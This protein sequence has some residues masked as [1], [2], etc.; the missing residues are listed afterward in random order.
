MKRKFLILLAI[1]A[2]Q[3]GS[4]AQVSG[5]SQ[6]PPASKVPPPP[7]GSIPSDWPVELEPY[8]PTGLSDARLRLD[9][10]VAPGTSQ[11]DSVL[12]ACYG[13]QLRRYAE[14]QISRKNYRQAAAAL[15]K[16]IQIPDRPESLARLMRAETN[17]TL[18]SSA[19]PKEK[20]KL[21][22]KALTD[23]NALLS[24]K[25]IQTK[26]AQSQLD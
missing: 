3:I 12:R 5:L 10:I 20:K 11:F 21:Y 7:P 2:S 22:R 8:L 18:A 1:V 13:Y 14:Q 6:L 26:F 19:A 15:D 25:E 4:A 16:A 24:A 9:L 23:S 17:L